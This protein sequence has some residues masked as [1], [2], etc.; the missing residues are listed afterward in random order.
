MRAKAQ[1]TIGLFF[2]T[3]FLV[4]LHALLL[5]AGRYNPPRRMEQFEMPLEQFM[6]PHEK[7]S[8]WILMLIPGLSYQDDFLSKDD[9]RGLVMKN[10]LLLLCI[11]L[12][13]CIALW[14][15]IFLLLLPLMVRLCFHQSTPI[16]TARIF[17]F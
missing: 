15:F 17:L 13:A 6:E 14:G 3:A 9:I 10:P 1:S 11:L 5:L 8:G 4:C 2:T 7:L 16:I 12:N